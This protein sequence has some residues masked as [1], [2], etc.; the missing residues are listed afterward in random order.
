MKLCRILLPILVL[1][2]CSMI[3]PT[4]TPIETISYGTH[5]NNLSE[6]PYFVFLPGRSSD[7]KEFQEEGFIDDARKSFPGAD[8]VAVEAHLGYYIRRNLITRLQEDIFSTAKKQGYKPIWLVGISMGGLG[9]VLYAEAHPE[10][11][12]GLYILAPFLGDKEVI[13]EIKQAGGLAKWSPPENLDPKDYQRFIWSWL[14]K[15][16]KSPP[17]DGLPDLFLGWGTEDRHADACKL[18]ADALPEGH[19]FTTKGDHDWPT[20]RTLWKDFLITV[21]KR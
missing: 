20:W 2:G 11:I 7:A 19:V 21:S 13:E 8:M 9:A 6:K 14:K 16:T 1:C 4:K 15:Y 3:Y 17:P 5:A 10:Q 12:D 18:L